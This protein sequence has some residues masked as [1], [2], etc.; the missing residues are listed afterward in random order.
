M[1]KDVAFFQSV[2][3]GS[4]LQKLFPQT[5]CIDEITMELGES[6]MKRVVS[7]S[8]V[9]MM[10]LMVAFNI[11]HLDARPGFSIGFYGVNYGIFQ[12][13][14]VSCLKK[15]GYNV[16]AV[17]E[18]SFKDADV[19]YIDY[20]E[21]FLRP[22]TEK[23]L[24]DYVENGGSLWVAGEALGGA[25]LGVNIGT[26][27]NS[28][29]FD[30]SLSDPRVGTI[31]H[32]ILQGVRS[33]VFPGVAS[34]EVGENIQEIMRIEGKTM[35]AVGS[36]GRGKIL[37]LIDTD[38]FGD[39]FLG[40]EDNSILAGNIAAWLCGARPPLRVANLSINPSQFNLRSIGEWITAYIELP[41]GYDV[42][43]INVSTAMLNDTVPAEVTPTHIGDHNNNSVPDLMVK[44]N[45]T[46]LVNLIVSENVTFD[47]VTLSLTGL[48]YNGT[49]F[50][51]NSVVAVSALMGDVN[52]DGQVS[53]PDL[54]ALAIAYH[55]GPE[56]P[57]WNDNANFAPPWD[58]I[59]LSEV[60]TLGAHYGQHY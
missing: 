60:A 10:L 44:F 16:F 33:V 48:L 3:S 32:P 53:L 58:A 6:E 40:Y 27:G 41:Q 39:F 19:V 49:Q 37:W 38:V 20:R 34:L 51:G 59:G 43:E 47:N 25:F 22:L 35:L 1:S 56:D 36:L 42:A 5:I 30:G 7:V 50:M 45:R 8:I 11:Q 9:V 23:N 57:N 55:S 21:P 31:E 29:Y 26:G 46:D 52:C 12:N 18:L 54:A 24:S 14:L 15:L 13:S 17:D 2:Q 4:F 28:V